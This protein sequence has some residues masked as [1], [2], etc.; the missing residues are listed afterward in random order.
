MSLKPYRAIRN[1]DQFDKKYTDQ[2]KKTFNDLSPQLKIKFQSF[3]ENLMDDE[4]I[5][6][7]K[8]LDAIHDFTIKHKEFCNGSDWKVFDDTAFNYRPWQTC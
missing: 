8:L 1:Y 7:F 2:L 5:L 4:Y 6:R 3:T